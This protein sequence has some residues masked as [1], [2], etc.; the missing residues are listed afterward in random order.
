MNVSALPLKNEFGT[1]LEQPRAIAFLTDPAEPV[2]VDEEM[3]RQLYGLT[4]A[5]CRLAGEICTGQ[6]ISAIAGRLGVSE[7]TV[8]T[9]LQSIFEKTGTHRQAQVVKL[10]LSLSSRN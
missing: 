10:M 5:E 1:G 3:L 6:S 7:N 4:G 8:K 9:Q 2:K